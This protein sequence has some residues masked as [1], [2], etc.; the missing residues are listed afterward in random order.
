MIIAC[1]HDV[2]KQIK[3][4]LIMHMRN[5]KSLGLVQMTGLKDVPSIFDEEED[6]ESLFFMVEALV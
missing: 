6:L 5:V 1:K 3:N 2:T 4:K